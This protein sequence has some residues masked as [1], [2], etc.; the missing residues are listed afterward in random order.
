MHETIWPQGQE[1]LGIEW[2]KYSENQFVEP[3]ITKLK[4]EGIKSSLPE[5]SKKAYTPP[6][7]RLIKEGKDPEQFMPRSQVKVNSTQTGNFYKLTYPIKIFL[8]SQ[9][10][11]HLLT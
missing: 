8:Q 11:K 4:P 1:L 5:A 10:N 2:Q 9:I 3:P 7:L 6:H